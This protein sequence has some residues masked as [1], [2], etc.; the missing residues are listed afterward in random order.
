MKISVFGSAL[1]QPESREFIDAQ[2]FGRIAA[3]E[4][5]E[6]TCGAYK[7]IML[8][9]AMGSKSEGGS[10]TGIVWNGSLLTPNEFVDEIIK[11]DEYLEMSSYLI[12]NSNI[13]IFFSGGTGT[14]MELATT[15]NLLEHN[16]LER[17]LIITIGEEWR[18][19][20]QLISFYNENSFE[21][22]L[23]IHNVEDSGEAIELIKQFHW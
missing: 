12:M 13:Y 20:V 17:K 18:E 7:G 22:G 3:I 4:G 14:L 19:L 9:T 5:W 11:V 15:W 16:L 23:F 10:V 8:A 2:N 21:S 6:I 1:A